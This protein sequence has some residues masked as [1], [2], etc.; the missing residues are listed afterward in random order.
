[1]NERIEHYSKV[2]STIQNTLVLA[3]NAAEQAKLS[4]QKEAE[5]VVK[6]ANDTAQRILDKAHNDV[7]NINEQYEIIKQEF[8]KFRAKFRT[9]MNAQMETFG[10]LEKDFIKTIT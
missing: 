7:L 9:F 2:E 3:Q 6:S 4:A 5:L 10:E 8:I 1:M